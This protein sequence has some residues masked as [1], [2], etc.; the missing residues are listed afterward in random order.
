M[1]IYIEAGGDIDQLAA[2]AK[3]AGV[4]LASDPHDTEWGARAFEVTDPSGF[5]FTIASPSS[6]SQ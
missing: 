2:R 5:L 1:R 4:T 3:A 6:P